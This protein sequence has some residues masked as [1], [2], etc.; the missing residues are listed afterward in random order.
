MPPPVAAGQVRLLVA[1]LPPGVSDAELIAV[2]ADAVLQPAL[3]TCRSERRARACHR[4]GVRDA[5]DGYSGIISHRW[6]LLAR[7]FE[8]DWEV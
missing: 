6:R 1:N 3:I 2:L 5:T 7:G 4:R 8:G